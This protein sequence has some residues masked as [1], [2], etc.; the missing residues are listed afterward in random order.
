MSEV[1]AEFNYLNL[2]RSFFRL[3]YEKVESVF[4]GTVTV[5]GAGKPRVGY[6]DEYFDTEGLTEWVIC[7]FLS[8]GIGI[9]SDAT[10]QL[11]VSTRQYSDPQGMNLKIWVDRVRGALNVNDFQMYDYSNAPSS[12]IIYF[13]GDTSSPLVA[14]LRHVGVTSL[15]VEDG[16]R[17]VVL[18]Y[19]THLWRNDVI[20]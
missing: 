18:D 16:V 2:E 20:E 19:D 5:D 12:S 11:V 3:V 14:A 8:Y 15:P 9:G 13:D 7:S 4:L 1:S 6:D 17:S 10:V